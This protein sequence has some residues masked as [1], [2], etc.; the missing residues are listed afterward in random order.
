MTILL[1]DSFGPK[2]RYYRNRIIST[3]DIRNILTTAYGIFILSTY[4]KL[5]FEKTKFD[6]FA[7]IK[8]CCMEYGCLLTIIYMDASRRTKN[9]SS[10]GKNVLIVGS[11]KGSDIWN[12]ALVFILVAE[13]AIVRNISP[14]LETAFVTFI[15]VFSYDGLRT[16]T[17]AAIPISIKAVLCAIL[18][19]QFLTLEGYDQLH[20][21]IFGC[22]VCAWQKANLIYKLR[23]TFLENNL[24]ML[25]TGAIIDTYLRPENDDALS[26]Y[27]VGHILSVVVTGIT[28]VVLTLFVTSIILTSIATECTAPLIADRRLLFAVLLICGIFPVALLHSRNAF[29]FLSFMLGG[30]HV[31]LAIYWAGLLIFFIVAAQILANTSGLPKFCVRKIFHLLMILIIVP[32]LFI[33]DLFCF[34][35]LAIGVALSLFL[36]L[37][38]FRVIAFKNTGED[39]ISTYYDKFIDRKETERFW[40]SSN[41]SLLV[42]CAF[43]AFLWAHWLGQKNCISTF[44]SSGFGLNPFS[45]VTC[46]SNTGDNDVVFSPVLKALRPLLPHLGWITVGVGD[47]FAA[48]VGSRFGRCKW[49]NSSRSVEG[50]FAM[51]ISTFFTSLLVLHYS[52]ECESPFS[53]EVLLPV[54]IT[55]AFASL[56]E[57]FSSENDNIVLPL[58]SVASYVAIIII[59]S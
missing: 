34:T 43:P 53:Y 33:Q 50:T 41:I 51:Y 38:T 11:F 42:G 15:A 57:A 26:H 29:R 19:N 22:S 59:I 28:T 8:Y 48:M 14:S 21:F 20:L 55:L 45:S 7:F 4:G 47:S 12:V 36:V 1:H 44:T 18:I 30:H 5:K 54:S 31:H 40:I 35:I 25:L 52:G 27:K 56:C 2:S 10:V 16:S 17:I 9:C 6:S 39:I 58:F 37:E 32:G 24:L 3:T 23:F 13:N 46:H 49:P